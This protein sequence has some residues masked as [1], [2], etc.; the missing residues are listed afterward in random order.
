MPIAIGERHSRQRC[1]IK[2]V[3]CGTSDVRTGCDFRIMRRRRAIKV[4][5]EET[6]FV[7]Y[8]YLPIVDELCDECLRWLQIPTPIPIAMTA[9]TSKPITIHGH[10]SAGLMI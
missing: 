4:S 7:R 10:L 2:D 3:L 8:P 6:L 5:R 9:A 1:I